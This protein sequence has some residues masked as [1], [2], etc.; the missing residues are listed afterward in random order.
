MVNCRIIEEDYVDRYE[1]MKEAYL[2]GVRG[3]RLREMFGIGKSAYKRLL[4]EFRED[5]IEIAHRGRVKV[6]STPKH[7]CLA[8]YGQYRY[9][10]VRR[11][12]NWKV[13]NFGYFKSE[14]EAQAKVRELEANGWEGLL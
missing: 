5:G 10:V 14:A 2:S 1:E 11:T 3:K 13:Y 4:N 6:G 8:T 7:Y 12:I 9:W